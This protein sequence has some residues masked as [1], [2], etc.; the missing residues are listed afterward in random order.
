[1]VEIHQLVPNFFRG[2]AISSQTAAYAE[3]F[4]SLGFKSE[5]FALAIEPAL[6]QAARPYKKYSVI[7]RPENLVFYHVSDPS[8][9]TGFFKALPDRKFIIYHN[10]TPQRFFKEAR[11]FYP[12]KR[13]EEVQSL[14]PVVE[15]AFGVSEFNCRD[16]EGLGFKDP[17][18]MP[19]VF[20][21]ADYSEAPLPDIQ[22]KYSDG[23]TNILFV[24]RIAPN[25]KIE[26]LLK[27][28][29]FYKTYFDQ[30]SRLIIAG[31]IFELFEPY[32]SQLIQLQESLGLE[33][34]VFTGHVSQPE[35]VSYYQTAS[36][37][38]SASEHEG[39]GLPFLE[40]MH[41]KIPVLAY[42]AAAVAET[43]GGAGL[44]YLKKDPAFVA[45]L[46]DKLIRDRTLSAALIEKQSL[47]VRAFYPG[48]IRE[49]LLAWLHQKNI[50]TAD[51]GRK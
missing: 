10:F 45:G 8:P 33:D 40:A 1:M 20:D 19:V 50:G 7:S 42:D 39:F 18:I 3:M 38:L 48:P 11:L 12:E 29:Y 9:V 26:D 5:V 34:I 35:L 21:P 51:E 47:R 43:L 2:D 32:Y 4:R 36:L 6:R 41:F 14:I 23:K 49:R 28:F 17:E 44:L 22:K 24:G 16:L 25:K 31:K 15:K 13:A 46:I 27:I 37:Y 30:N